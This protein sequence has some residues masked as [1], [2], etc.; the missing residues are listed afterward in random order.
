MTYKQSI[1]T[2]TD[3]LMGQSLCVWMCAGRNHRTAGATKLPCDQRLLL[4]IIHRWI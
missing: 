3:L 4:P 1:K 2:L